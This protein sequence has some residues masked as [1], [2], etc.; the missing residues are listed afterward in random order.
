MVNTTSL[1]VY[2]CVYLSVNEYIYLTDC[3]TRLSAPHHSACRLITVLRRRLVWKSYEKEEVSGTS[4][5]WEVQPFHLVPW[6]LVFFCRMVVTHDTCCFGVCC[7]VVKAKVLLGQLVDGIYYL[8]SRKIAHRWDYAS[9]D[10]LIKY[11][12]LIWVFCRD[13]KIENI[14]LVSAD[15]DVDI[16]ITGVT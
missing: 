2:V 11:R 8:H 1:F 12:L 3:N 4:G 5:A 6:F 9:N 13:L 16:K 7:C 15:N 14:M 10:V